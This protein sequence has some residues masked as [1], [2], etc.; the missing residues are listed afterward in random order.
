MGSESMAHEAKG[1][2]GYWLRGHE[3]ERNNN[4]YCFNKIQL[5]VKKNAKDQTSF[6]S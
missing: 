4:Y 3:S 5:V 6:A 2:M 1:Q